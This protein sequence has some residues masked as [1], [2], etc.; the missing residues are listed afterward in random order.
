MMKELSTFREVLVARDA[1]MRAMRMFFY[2]RGFLEVETPIRLPAPCLEE[3]IDA[4][5]ADGAFLRTSPELHMKRLLCAGYD[6]IFCVGS[7]FRRHEFGRLHNPE[8]T[9]LE[10]YRTRADYMDILDD[11][12][13][14]VGSVNQQLGGEE[15]PEWSIMTVSEAFLKYAGWDPAEEYDADR[16]DLDLLDKVEPALKEL[17]VVVLKEYPAAAAALSRKKPENTKVAE[18]F[19]LYINGIEIANAYSELTDAS[20]QRQRF[21]E[22]AEARDAANKEVYPLDE[23]FLSA[24]EQGM[25]ECG[26][27][28]VGMDRLLMVLLGKTSLDEILPFR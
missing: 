5:P 15:L 10:W 4:I 16:F 27:I 26:G 21:E 18:R 7:C 9:M 13:L 25:P 12:R 14:L 23:A 8:Y 28:A 20:E 24:L 11:L 17:G 22:C 19:E 3:Y 2:E 6:K 1:M